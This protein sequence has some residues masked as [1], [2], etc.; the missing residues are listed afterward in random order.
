MKHNNEFLFEMVNLDDYDQFN[1]FFTDFNPKK[2]LD[3]NFE[4]IEG[5]IFQFM[6]G[7]LPETELNVL[8]TNL[9]DYLTQDEVYDYFAMLSLS[10]VSVT[11]EN[12]EN[13]GKFL[14]I[15]MENI[16]DSNIDKFYRDITYSDLFFNT[17]KAQKKLLKDSFP[18][19][20]I[21]NSL[22]KSD[23][24]NWKVEAPIEDTE[25]VVITDVPDA[26]IDASGLNTDELSQKQWEAYKGLKNL[27]GLEIK[28]DG[29][30]MWVSGDTYK[31]KN[32]IKSFGFRWGGKRKA[33]YLVDKTPRIVEPEEDI[34]KELE[35]PVKPIEPVTV[36]QPSEPEIKAPSPATIPTPSTPLDTPEKADDVELKSVDNK[37]HLL[38]TYS[39][40]YLIQMFENPFDDEVRK[41]EEIKELLMKDINQLAVVLNRLVTYGIQEWGDY[42]VLPNAKK[43]VDK[44]NDKGWFGDT[45]ISL[46]NI[47]L[48]GVKN[49]LVD[50]RTIVQATNIAEMF[51]HKN[52]SIMDWND[53]HVF[54][55]FK[56]YFRKINSETGD[57]FDRISD[58]TR[59][60]DDVY[61]YLKFFRKKSNDF[62]TYLAAFSHIGFGDFLTKH[63]LP[64][65]TEKNY[66]EYIEF[67]YENSNDMGALFGIGLYP[68]ID[69]RYD[70]VIKTGRK[71][72]FDK[73][74]KKVGFTSQYRNKM[75]SNGLR[76]FVVSQPHVA[77]YVLMG[78]NA[79]LID[80]NFAEMIIEVS[81]LYFDVDEKQEIIMILLGSISDD[82]GVEIF[83]ASFMDTV[84]KYHPADAFDESYGIFSG[85]N[86]LADK[87]IKKHDLAIRSD[88]NF[89]HVFDFQ[90]IRKDLI[91]NSVISQ[92]EGTLFFEKFLKMLIDNIVRH[93]NSV[94]EHEGA[95]KRDYRFSS[96]I[97]GL[98]KGATKIAIFN[99]LKYWYKKDENFYDE[100]GPY[101]RNSTFSPTENL[102]TDIESKIVV[103]MGEEGTD[104]IIDGILDEVKGVKNKITNKS[105]IVT[106][107]GDLSDLNGTWRDGKSKTG[108]GFP[109]VF[110]SR[111]GTISQYDYPVTEINKTYSLNFMANEGDYDNFEPISGENVLS[112]NMLLKR[113][114]KTDANLY[115]LSFT[116]FVNDE[117]TIL[118]AN[119]LP[120]HK[121]LSYMEPI[122]EFV[123][124]A[125]LSEIEDLG[126]GKRDKFIRMIE[127]MFYFYLNNGK[128][129]TD[130]GNYLV[131]RK[132]DF[133]YINPDENTL[134]RTDYNVVI[135]TVEKF[136]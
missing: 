71:Y 72:G 42:H 133:K 128:K 125:E 73:L 82:K 53:M 11:P 136:K 108:K 78:K 43:F 118:K 70:D 112:V 111:D 101:I 14:Q 62:K 57:L 4:K 83:D 48:N 99:A 120:L 65:I 77:K 60:S 130:K 129:E 98:Y 80:S 131:K 56:K 85:N 9:N 46:A 27:D 38:D 29:T 127:Q 96:L 114:K 95:L 31:H 59:L 103:S 33:W 74:D 32:K 119:K 3:D 97:T 51:F 116:M 41:V 44:A 52:S 113:A 106:L 117:K 121:V 28:L 115:N 30:W 5:K 79:G 21:Y 6:G 36:T 12:V 8:Y 102:V 15:H 22:F 54:S 90:R 132:F 105:D 37:G 17:L 2:I 24:E 10:D 87:F 35:T 16:G 88:N 75:L 110:D 124:G 123:Y 61:P 67:A 81:D 34:A 89:L 7:K 94:V 45:H 86:K 93:N 39:F 19:A 47:L 66:K 69:L 122:L 23:I 58:S 104:F 55:K 68:F 25:E 49:G 64:N 13:V 1:D 100:I 18:D 76:N 50:L 126:I 107:I 134:N 91:K 26:N 135:D 40:G 109:F 63:V 92:K 84:D 20:N